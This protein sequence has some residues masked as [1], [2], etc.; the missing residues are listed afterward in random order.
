[1]G[2][3]ARI[4]SGEP[5]FRPLERPEQGRCPSYGTTTGRPDSTTSI[6]MKNVEKVR[7][8]I[9][10][11]T[12]VM[13]TTAYARS[14]LEGQGIDLDSDP[15]VGPV[16]LAAEAGGLLAEMEER[17]RYKRPGQ[18]E[19]EHAKLYAL[20]RSQVVKTDVS[21]KDWAAYVFDAS[22]FCFRTSSDIEE[23]LGPLRGLGE[24]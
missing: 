4:I 16:D 14:F 11:R 9:A 8:D 12:V 23:F 6:L 5:R 24:N 3:L 10:G 20:Y 15:V 19:F 7:Q 1:M 18:I 17:T 13:T 22:Y 21:G 2:L